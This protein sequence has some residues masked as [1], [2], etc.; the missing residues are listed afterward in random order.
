MDLHHVTLVV[1]Y[2]VP[3]F[4]K[5]YVHRCGRTARAGKSGRAVTIVKGGQ[6]GKFMKMRQLIQ[7]PKNVTIGGIRKDLIRDAV[8]VY[9]KCV[10]ALQK[11]LDAEE[12]NEL[13]SM[14]PLGTQWVQNSEAS[15]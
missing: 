4:A 5:T 1:H 9:K 7:D 11:V 15:K 13:S 12:N 6:V 3:S 10:R 2:D 8:P 14:H